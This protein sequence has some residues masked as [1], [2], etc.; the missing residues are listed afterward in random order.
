MSISLSE[1]LKKYLRGE[2]LP[3]E[4]ILIYDI[5]QINVEEYYEEYLKGNNKDGH[6]FI[7]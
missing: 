6:L 5:L 7:V 4:L 3:E 2:F 1:G